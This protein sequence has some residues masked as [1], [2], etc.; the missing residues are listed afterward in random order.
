MTAADICTTLYN[1][2]YCYHSEK[3]LQHGVGQVL[4]DLNLTFK[5]EYS[6]APRDRIDF[7]ITD[8]GIG[9]ECKSDDS[10]GGTSLA[11]V[12]R[13]LM[14]YAQHTE[15]VELILLTTMS[16]HKNL[17]DS[18]NGKPLYIVHLLLSFL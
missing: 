15:V 7:L 14:R 6:L 18:L 5:P 3:E 1:T 11:S 13:Q 2:K 4:T 8:L 9:I 17:P 12:T 10:G 16:K